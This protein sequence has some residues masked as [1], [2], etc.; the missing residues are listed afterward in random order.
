M[1]ADLP[2]DGPD[3]IRELLRILPGR[4][5]ELRSAHRELHLEGPDPGRRLPR[6]DRLHGAGITGP[7]LRPPA[8]RTTYASPNPIVAMRR[9]IFDVVTDTAADCYGR[10]LIRVGD[11]RVPEDR[12][13]VPGPPGAGTG[14]D[15]DK[16]LAWPA[17]LQPART[18]W[19]TPRPTSPRSWGPP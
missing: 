15:R 8:C 17:D 2:E 16:K 10:Y 7:V 13:A 9:T 5:H 3:R 11:A 19:A 6:P 4:L 12:A 1:A 18:G 14:D